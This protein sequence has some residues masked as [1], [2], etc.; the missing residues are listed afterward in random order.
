MFGSKVSGSKRRYGYSGYYKPYKRGRWGS[1]YGK[2]VGSSKAAKTGNKISYYNAQV[3]GY[4]SF[5]FASGAFTSNVQVFHPYTAHGTMTGSGSSAKYAI[6]EEQ[7]RHGGAVWDKG[8]RLMCAMNDE[9]RLCRMNVKLQPATTLPN[10]VAVR[11][12]SVVDRNMTYE[13]WH[14]LYTGAVMDDS[15][16]ATSILE[17]QGAVMQTFNGNRVAP[18]YRFSVP[19]D[20]K[21]KTGWVD[22]SIE[23]YKAVNF[24]PLADVMLHGWYKGETT[25]APAFSYCLQTSVAAAADTTITFGYTVEYSFA[26]RNPKSGLDFFVKQE[27]IGY[28]NPAGRALSAVVKTEEVE[29]SKEPDKA[30]EVVEEKEDHDPGTS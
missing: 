20:L 5:D 27:Q 22:C 8:F 16:N 13:E 28:V 3:S 30:A 1:T 24:S 15:F 19:T 23:Y 10:N 7:Y 17:S 18:L 25:Y 14:N 6:T 11:L 29:E 26:F 4:V 12:A 9:C 2:S 21:E